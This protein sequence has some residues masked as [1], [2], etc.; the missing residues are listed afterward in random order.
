MAIFYF[1]LAHAIR[2]HDQIIELSGGLPG[3]KDAGQ[4]DSVLEHIQNDDYYPDLQDKL[5]H[6]VFAVAKFHCFNDGTS[7]PLSRWVPTSSNSTAMT[8]W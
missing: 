2:V 6:L 4:I 1:D 3:T 8:G 5:T 7:A